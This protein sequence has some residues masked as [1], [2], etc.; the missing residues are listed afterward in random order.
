MPSEHLIVNRMHPAR[1]TAQTALGLQWREPVFYSDE[2]KLPKDWE[3]TCWLTQRTQFRE[4]S[5]ENSSYF[6]KENRQH[7]YW[8]TLLK[9]PWEIQFIQQFPEHPIL[10]LVLNGK[11]RGSPSS[12][13]NDS[14]LDEGCPWKSPTSVCCTH[15]SAGSTYSSCLMM[16]IHSASFTDKCV[17]GY[18]HHPEWVFLMSRPLACF[19]LSTAL[20]QM[21][22]PATCFQFGRFRGGR[23]VGM[24]TQT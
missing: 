7:T 20:L 22:C 14:S 12:F 21:T 15:F 19:T 6:I 11:R 16:L 1:R 18:I 17:F 24:E 23:G 9:N 4:H 3:T 5:S 13:I 10:Y 2:S 8:A